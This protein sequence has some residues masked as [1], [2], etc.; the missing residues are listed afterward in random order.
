MYGVLAF[1]A[2]QQSALKRLGP[3]VLFFL[4]GLPK[5]DA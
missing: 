4:E 3:S 5:M 1:S 2:G